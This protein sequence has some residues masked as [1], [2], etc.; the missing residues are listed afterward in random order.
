M[1]LIESIKTALVSYDKDIIKH[2][3]EDTP[4]SSSDMQNELSLLKSA[5][6]SLDI[7]ATNNAIDTLLKLA[8]SDDEKKAIRNISQHVLLFEYDKANESIN[9][10]IKDLY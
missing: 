5:L 7:V 9:D 4:G 3:G 2:T 8:R 10:L 6:D 1:K